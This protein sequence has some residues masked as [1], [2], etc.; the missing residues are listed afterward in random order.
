LARLES[1]VR[2]KTLAKGE[3][4]LR[5]GDRAEAA[6]FV[7]TGVLRYY[8]L[9]DGVEHTGQFFDEGR[10]M[11]DIAALTT[12]APALQNIDALTPAEVLMIPH[13]ALLAAY[14]ADHGIE[15][16]GRRAL[17]ESMAGSQRRTANLLKLSPADRYAAFVRN[18]PEVAR[19]VPQYV[20]ASYLGITPEA[21]SRIR[22][23]RI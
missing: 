13:A 17:E 5:E 23:R 12:G 19:R 7:R 15:R 6:F 9:A 20:I 14:D 22:R 18:R 16:Y 10:M 11:G 4:I 3:H 8:Y 1:A 2:V 21:L